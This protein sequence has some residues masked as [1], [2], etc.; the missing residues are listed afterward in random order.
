MPLALV[1]IIVG[2]LLLPLPGWLIDALIVASNLYAFWLVV[3]VISAASA[4]ELINLPNNLLLSTVLRL[5]LNVATTRCILSGSDSGQLIGLI[6]HTV[7]QD[8]LVTGI[9]VFGVISVILM[10]VITKGA[11]RVAEVAARFALDGLPGRQMTIDADVRSGLISFES[12]QKKREA[13]QTESKLCGALDGC[14]KFIKG[15]VL[16]GIIIML[17]NL[18]GG[19]LIASIHGGGSLAEAFHKFSSLTIGDGLASQI[20]SF[21][22]AL[23][24]GYILTKIEGVPGDELLESSLHGRFASYLKVAGLFVGVMGL[25]PGAPHLRLISLGLATL[26]IGMILSKRDNKEIPVISSP[27]ALPAFSQSPKIQISVGMTEECSDASL[28]TFAMETLNEFHRRTG[29][30]LPVVVGVDRSEQITQQ[31][32][33]LELYTRDIKLDSREMELQPEESNPIRVVLLGLL[34]ECLRHFLSDHYLSELLDQLANSG[35]ESASQIKSQ[36]SQSDLIPI[37]VSLVEHKIPLHDWDILL[38]IFLETQSQPS[39]RRR[40]E[41]I[42]N[43]LALR[44][45]SIFSDDRGVIHSYMIAQ[46]LDAEIAE[47]EFNSR[48]L[49][50]S[51]AH[52]LLQQFRELPDQACVVCSA[53]TATLLRDYVKFRGLSIGLIAYDEVVEPFQLKVLGVVDSSK[54]SI[55]QLGGSKS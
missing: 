22:N 43:K 7:I 52:D 50:D 17:T 45:C 33:R 1:L 14:M 23:A 44:I 3:S 46:Q 31:K 30:L 41:A 11:E 29:L 38:A 16:V 47:C 49:E 15:D 54:E 2:S 13:L 6:G 34:R 25:M 40:L 35:L 26:C 55:P 48:V 39:A 51:I 5:S 10:L 20:P 42:R 4:Q 28:K 27:K 21:L 9:V 53:M 32:I 12:A 36:G 18:L 8:G 24:A 37:I 19:I